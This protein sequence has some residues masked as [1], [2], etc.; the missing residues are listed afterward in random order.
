MLRTLK[1]K[2][3]AMNLVST[4]AALVAVC[5]VLGWYDY[6]SFRRGMVTQAQTF[7]NV[8]ASNSTAA[9]SFGD[10]NDAAQTLASL[11]FEPHVVAACVYDPAGKSLATYFRDG[12]RQLSPPADLTPG[13][14]RFLNDRLEVSCPIRLNGAVLGSAYIQSDLAA[15]R[16]RTHA[17][18][19]VFGAAI[20]GAMAV[21]LVLSGR[22]TRFILRPVEHLSETATDVSVNRNYAVRARKTSDDELG[23]LVSCFNAMLDQIEERDRQL[24]MHRDHLEE[25]VGARTAELSTAK[26]KAEEANRAKSNF[27]A[28]MSHEIRTPMTAI[29]GYADLMLSPAQTMSDR[30]NSLQVIRRN[31][32]HL[33]DLI[34]DI[35]DISKIEAEKMTVEK[36]ACDPARIAVEVI[37]MLRPRAI[38][39]NLP[40]NVEFVGAIPTEIKT[41]PVRLKQVLMNLTGNAIK[42]TETGEVRIKVSAERSGKTSRIRFDVIDTGIGMTPEQVGRLF[43]P[44]VQADESMTRK[45]GGSGLGLVISKRLATFM[46]GDLSIT[47]QLGRG[48]TF[49]FWIDGGSLDGVAMREGLTESVL[50]IAQDG[51]ESE[52][53]A[54]SAR[55]LLVE[56]G[57]D[58]QHLLSMYLTMAGAEVVVAENGQAST[59]CIEW[60]CRGRIVR[61]G[62]DGHADA[63]AGRVQRDERIAEEGLHAADY[64]PHRPRH[65]RRSRQMHCRRM[66]RLPD[67]TDRSGVVA[68]N[69]RKLSKSEAG[70]G[71]AACCAQPPWLQRRRSGQPRPGSNSPA[72]RSNRNPAC[73]NQRHDGGGD[74]ASRRRIR[75]ATSCQSGCAARAQRGGRDGGTSPPHAPVEGGGDGVRICENQR[76]RRPRRGGHQGRRRL[77]CNPRDRG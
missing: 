46:G 70:A 2:L 59:V 52:Q 36:I 73:P 30:I 77:R 10:S 22:L 37:S 16:A 74:E 5:A 18:V 69:R 1:S 45:Y 51:S 63:G 28:N 9:L 67:Q 75:L 44:F 17:Y 3:L 15:L 42:F 29:F 24:T 43:Q 12:R 33:M 13:A 27:L 19:I 56:D 8:V 58:N 47:S 76:N 57:I 55:I 39:K 23:T 11:R 41:D 38:G 50:G 25:L 34:N 7:A 20:L 48:S 26:D 65:E 66:H 32:R 71:K 53:I 61:S 14:Y 68:S 35:L 40:L 6:Q 60:I 31:A 54:L 49:S 64:R 4:G 21:A 62:P 72:T